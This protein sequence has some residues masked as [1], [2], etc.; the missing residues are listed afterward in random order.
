MTG[1]K[2]M[3][4]LI[5]T[6][7]KEFWLLNI[8]QMLEK[9]AYW[10][11]LLQMPIYTAQ[12]GIEGGLN[13]EQYVKGIVFFVWAMIQNITPVFAGGIA[14]RYG[15]KKLLMISIL[16][17]S[18]SYSILATQRE[19]NP[20]LIGVILLGIGSGIF[21]PSLQGAMTST[22][23]KESSSV[24]WGLYF[25]LMN[26][27]IIAAPPLSKYLH[28]LSWS[29][30]FWGSA[31]VILAN[32]AFIFL[33]NS[34]RNGHNSELSQESSV[35]Y[36]QV[37]TCL[38]K[39]EIFLFLVCMSGFAIIYMQFYETLPNFIYDWSDTSK[40][41]SDL[42]LPRFMLMDTPR[43]MMISYEWLYNLNTI[44]VTMFVVFTAWLMGLM[45]RIK[46]IIIGIV[47]SILGLALTSISIDGHWLVGGIIIYTFG[48]MITNPKFN[49]YLSSIAPKR[50]ESSYMSYLNIS[51]AIGLGGG[52]LLGGFFYGRIAEKSSLALSYI[53]SH[54][55]QFSGD[56][57]LAFNFL[58][59]SLGYN[60]QQTTL[61]LWETYS[62]NLIW[63]PFLI[64]GI[65]SVIGLLFYRRKYISS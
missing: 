59:K 4:V 56:N 20:F 31:I 34:H 47:L 64:I 3:I 40:L 21:K 49:D 28:E 10:S 57:A 15:R 35:N 41:A 1:F 55:L 26:F 23:P 2:Q 62:P 37:F 50:L 65:A 36:K 14:D 16:I 33:L 39:P 17:I 11:V 42:S 61:M 58:S 13:W 29:A 32:L 24:G 53:H 48:E 12:K 19:F 46:A 6:F 18:I 60:P 45:D 22:M 38:M 27:A 30:V 44:L 7:P 9:L 52:S 8:I 54:G 25:M 51:M 43:G 63:I 5:R